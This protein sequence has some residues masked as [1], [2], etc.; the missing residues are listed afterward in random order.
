MLTTNLS[1]CANRNMQRKSPLLIERI[2]AI[3]LQYQERS[4]KPKRE[5]KK[6]PSG[7]DSIQ[8]TNISYLTYH[9][10]KIAARSHP[11]PRRRT[12]E[13]NKGSSIACEWL[14][15]YYYFHLIAYMNTNEYYIAYIKIHINNMSLSRTER[16]LALKSELRQ[17]PKY[18]SLVIPLLILWV[19][20]FSH[21]FGDEG[22]P[23][24]CNNT[25]RQKCSLSYS[26]LL[27]WFRHHTDRYMQTHAYL[28][29]EP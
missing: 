16:S 22:Q 26:F 13:P 1:S 2:R 7:R 23:N 18:V 19:D 27:D 14:R 10:H 21:V 20:F 8:F 4:D 29:L 28:S 11:P 24:L 3:P 5:P 17:M 15:W 9:I 6:K 25:I 12:V